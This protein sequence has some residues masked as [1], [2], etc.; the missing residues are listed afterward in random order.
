MPATQTACNS[1]DFNVLIIDN[2]PESVRVLLETF[3]KRAIRGTVAADEKRTLEYA[4]RNIW[5]MAL[6]NHDFCNSFINVADR[7]IIARLKENHPEIPMV[8]LTESSCRTA[9]RKAIEMGY[10]KVFVKPVLPEMVDELL[11]TFAP[12]HDTQTLAYSKHDCDYPYKIVGTSPKLMSTVKIARKIAPT[13]APVLITGESGTGKELIAELI[14]AE[15]KRANGPFV[16][17]N[18]AALNDSLLESE[19]FGHEKGAFTGAGTQHKGR[20]ERAHGGTLLLDEITETQPQFQA[21][22][23]R[24]LENMNF[25]RVGGKENINVN[26]RIISTTNMDILSEVKSKRFRS[27]LYYRLAAIRLTVPALRQRTGD[28]VALVWL[29]VNQFAHEAARPITS[30]DTATLEI[31]ERHHWPGNVRQLRNVVRTALILGSDQILSL[32]DAPWLIEELTT[33]NP[34]DSVDTDWLAGRSLR[35]LERKAILATLRQTQGNQTRAAKALGIS[36]RTLRDKVKKYRDQ[37]QLV[38]TR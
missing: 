5:N 12:N 1:T 23:L 38:S 28:I 6:I 34:A 37:N 13:S 22:L 7:R 2:D 15:S 4:D 14:H 20:F 10:S 21:K 25:E 32:A 36:D 16:K 29:F 24:V 3:A 33:A 27:D 19:L 31:L 18:C 26:V 17:V 30:V 9:P 8:M 11:D 35:D